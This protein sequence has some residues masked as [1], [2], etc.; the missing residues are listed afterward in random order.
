MSETAKYYVGIDVG[1]VSVD[2]ALLSPDGEVMETKYIRHHGRP[3][4]VAGTALRE[5]VESLGRENLLG[6]AATGNAGRWSPS[7]STP[8]S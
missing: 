4:R 1:S 3:L 8:R 5:T 7:A 2:L 6:I